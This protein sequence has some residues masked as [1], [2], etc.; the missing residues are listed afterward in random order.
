MRPI[1]NNKYFLI[2]AFYK[3]NKFDANIESMGNKCKKKSLQKV[4]IYFLADLQVITSGFL[5]VV[6][7]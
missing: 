7:I 1:I 6:I 2:A 3:I 4:C 5:F